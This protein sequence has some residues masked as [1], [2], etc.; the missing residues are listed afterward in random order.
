MNEAVSESSWPSQD[1]I[2]GLKALRDHPALVMGVASDIL[3]P[4]WQQRE[5]AETLRRAG[6]NNVTH[7]ELGED[8]SLF[9]HDSFLLDLEHIGGNLKQF[10]G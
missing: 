3:F 1:L 8:V 9:G 4:A 5:I 2:L 7:I 10:L 6:N